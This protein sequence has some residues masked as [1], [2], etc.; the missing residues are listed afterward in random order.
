MELLTVRV[1]GSLTLC[2]LVGPLSSY[3]V[4]SPTPN[5]RVCAESYCILHV[6]LIFLETWFSLNGNGG[7]DL[8]KRVW[9]DWE[10]RM[11]G[12]LSTGWIESKAKE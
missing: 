10:E 1:G 7:V 5:M 2:L 8:G 9:G 11:E 12:K 4:A 6:Q 3:W